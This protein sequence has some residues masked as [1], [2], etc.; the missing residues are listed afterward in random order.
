MMNVNALGVDDNVPNK[1]CDNKVD[2]NVSRTCV[3]YNTKTL[4]SVYP[5]EVN[6]PN[7]NSDIK[8]SINELG[9]LSLIGYLLF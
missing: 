2:D 9:V 5:T 6:S 8:K 4:E 7:K 3:E 1:S